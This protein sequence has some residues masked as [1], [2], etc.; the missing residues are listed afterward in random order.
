[1]KSEGSVKTIEK[2]LPNRLPYPSLNELN[3]LAFS[4]ITEEYHN[5][6]INNDSRLFCFNKPISME[7]S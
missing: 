6:Q 4:E 1:M 5:E 3:F 2:V 7:F